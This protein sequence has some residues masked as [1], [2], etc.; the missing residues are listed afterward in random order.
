M[1]KVRDAIIAVTVMWFLYAVYVISSIQNTI[2]VVP[3]VGRTQNQNFNR[4]SFEQRQAIIHDAAT[5]V[6]QQLV[7]DA[8]EHAWKGYSNVFGQDEWQP[9]ARK[10]RTWMNVGLTIIDSLDT[11]WIT[12]MHHEFWK[13]R[14]WV[15][16]SCCVC[17]MNIQ[18]YEV[19]SFGAGTCR[20]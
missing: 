17:G 6:Q 7:K 19:L 5:K 10:A 4:D 1:V 13:C 9:I 12:G 20:L 8:F 15:V 16:V 2:V 3:N 14:D 11:L 18:T